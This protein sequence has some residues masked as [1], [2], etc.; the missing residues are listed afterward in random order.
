MGATM[1]G[2]PLRH[3]VV[4]P[5]GLHRAEPLHHGPEGRWIAGVK[6]HA[7]P[8]RSAGHHERPA[9]PGQ[10][11]LHGGTIQPLSLKQHLGAIARLVRICF[12][13]C[14]CPQTDITRDRRPGGDGPYARSVAPETVTSGLYASGS[15]DSATTGRA[16]NI[17]PSQVP[18]QPSRK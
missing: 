6:M 12:G 10:R 17:S 8:L 18:I 4:D 16:P 7:H 13:G 14:R 15:G 11:T 2:R 1:T 9:H 5:E 3:E